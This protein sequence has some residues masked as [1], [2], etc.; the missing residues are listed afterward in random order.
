[1]ARISKT[2]EERIKTESKKYQKV[3]LDAVAR[4]I[5]E[6]D[7]VIIIR[8][9]LSDLFGYNKYTDITSEYAIRG[10]Y[11]DLVVIVE[12][13]KHFVIEVKAIGLPLKENHLKQAIGYAS[14][15]GLDWA[16]LT[17][18]ASWQIYKI[19]FQK[20]IDYELV[21]SFD[22]LNMDIKDSR[23]LEMLYLLSKEGITKS[24]IEE[25]HIQNQAM[26]RYAIAALL[27][28]ET[29]I[30]TLRRELKRIH[31]DVKIAP[32]RL[33]EII[34]NDIIKRDIIE[35]ERFIAETKRFKKNSKKTEKNLTNNI[36]ESKIDCGE[37]L[38]IDSANIRNEKEET[39]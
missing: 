18:G 19:S 32:E 25:Y 8:D 14:N 24:A 3:L 12:G 35:H 36:T 29:V 13:K 5:N 31:T 6:S 1:M 26:N 2:T 34:L 33:H 16:V 28:N 7:T 22:F 21:F 39:F 17:N 20:P 4:D 11:C 15:E 10:T 37:H 30:S 23:C 27:L 9:M 38:P